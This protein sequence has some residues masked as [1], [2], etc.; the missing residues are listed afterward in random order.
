MKTSARFFVPFAALAALSTAACGGKKPEPQSEPVAETRPLGAEPDA[1]AP[2]QADTAATDTGTAPAPTPAGDA[3]PAPAG[4]AASAGDTA[5]AAD[6]TPAAVVDY[7]RVV[8]PHHDPA[9]PSV[10]AEFK[11]FKVVEAHVDLTRPETAKAVIEIDAAS[12]TTGVEDRDTHV[13]SPDFLD[14]AKFATLRVTVDRVK[15]VENAPDTFDAIATVDLHGVEK[16]VPVRFK[17]VEK[18]ADGAIVVEGE[19]KGLARADWGIALPPEKVGVAAT[20]DA[21][22]RLTLTNV[23]PAPVEK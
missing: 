7:F 16:E 2:A 13:K 8:A 20:L 14:V 4:D 10:T 21:Q 6:A 3:A 18:R 11:T 9:K 5:A 1:A 22:L 17:V 15:P 19:T 23:T 12:V